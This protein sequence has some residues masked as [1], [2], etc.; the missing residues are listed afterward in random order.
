M[1]KWINLRNILILTSVI[2][3]L[4]FSLS[5]PSV[6]KS[7]TQPMFTSVSTKEKG[8]DPD[9]DCV[10]LK[11]DLEDDDTAHQDSPDDGKVFDLIDDYIVAHGPEKSAQ[12]YEWLGPEPEPGSR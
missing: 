2:A 10:K 9:P 1:K 11:K 12:C 8:A 5:I 4:A 7:A 3:A 6:V